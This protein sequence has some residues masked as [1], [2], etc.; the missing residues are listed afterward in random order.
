M[1]IYCQYGIACSALRLFNV[2]GPGQN[3]SNLRQGM[4]SIFLAQAVRDRHVVIKG[5]GQRYRDFIYLDDVV[6][7]FCEVERQLNGGF[8]IYNVCTGVKTTVEELFAQIRSALPFEV[9]REYKGVTPGD[10]FGIV[11]DGSTLEQA[12]NW[13]PQTPL[14]VGLKTMI[15]WAL[16]QKEV[17]PGSR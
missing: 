13:K 17:V 6:H 5:S 12:L 15:D 9:S 11:G 7:A 14:T 8:S 3:W 1:R 10:Q 16:Q 2:Y 4:V